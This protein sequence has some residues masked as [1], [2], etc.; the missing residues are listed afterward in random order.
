MSRKINLIGNIRIS[1]AV[2]N[3]RRWEAEKDNGVEVVS[4]ENNRRTKSKRKIH[5][6]I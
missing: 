6:L 5:F 3:L 2:V 1:A 4:R